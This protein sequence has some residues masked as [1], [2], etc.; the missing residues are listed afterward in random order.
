MIVQALRE[1][2]LL[3][4][5]EPAPHG[6]LTDAESERSGPQGEAEL[7]VLES[8]LGAGQRSQSGVSV[9]VEYAQKRWCE[10]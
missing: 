9:H 2:R 4:A 3:G 7:R 8:H 5:G 1:A 6:L 10:C